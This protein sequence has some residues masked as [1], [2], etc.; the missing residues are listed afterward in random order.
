[1]TDNHRPPGFDLPNARRAALLR[2]AVTVLFCSVTMPALVACGGGSSA[3]AVQQGSG[4]GSGGRTS[5]GTGTGGTSGGGPAASSGGDRDGGSAGGAGGAGGAFGTGSG[6]V[7]IGATSAT[8]GNPSS[9]GS[10]TG[11]APAG[12]G[13][14]TIGRSDSGGS[15]GSGGR[16]PATSGGA[17]G[18]AAGAP[19]IGGSPPSGGA[20]AGAEPLVGLAG[21]ATR[22]L[23]T[24][25]QAAQFSI[26]NYFARSGTLGSL[27]ADPWVPTAGVTLPAS[28]TYLVGPGGKYTTVQAAVD[29][30]VAVG[31]STR[32]YIQIEA[33]V[34][35]EQVCVVAT[36]PPVTLYGTDTDAS[37]TVI[38]HA[39]FQGGIST[40]GSNPC[41]GTD[42][43][44]Q[45]A[46]LVV[47]SAGFEAKNL[48]IQNSVTTA[49]IGSSAKSQAVSLATNADRV[50]LDNVRVLSHQ[51]TLYLATASGTVSR[52]Y[53]KDSYFSG[54]VDFV[55]GGATA[56]FDHCTV[57]FVSD[58]G[59]TSGY[60]LSPS[61]DSRNP[62][63]FL[64]VNSTFTADAATPPGGVS[65]GRPWDQSCT[66]TATYVST[67][68]PSGK[69]PNGQ[70]TVTQSA[71]GAAYSPTAPWGAAA[72]TKRNYS[73]VP[74]AC[75]VGGTCPAN[76]LYEYNDVLVP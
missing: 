45:A 43:N 47:L 61:T 59:K 9:S 22:P 8:G 40:L 66:D 62:Y 41:G 55:F 75:V 5:N 28:T 4:S 69:Y 64:V 32:L 70:A 25:S 15:P 13:A 3:P 63:G 73:S 68:V 30:A 18:S 51:D 19:G 36:A 27:K 1:M 74:W 72:T 46:T 58:R 21:T 2:L 44:M 42:A 6:G 35:L 49:Q 20:L 12:G 56:V 23:L 37:K 39:D 11:G 16:S 26:A 54:D 71:I 34:Y 57:T 38:Q 60:A 48:T 7:D 67:C 10:S 29:A 14:S 53:A 17:P 24:D 65:L 31:G 50:A 52:V 76:R 33:G